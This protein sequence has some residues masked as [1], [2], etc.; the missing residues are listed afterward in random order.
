MLSKTKQK[1]NF[2]KILQ[3]RKKKKKLKKTTYRIEQIAE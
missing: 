2:Y 3:K 1:L